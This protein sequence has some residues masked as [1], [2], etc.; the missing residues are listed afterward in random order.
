MNYPSASPFRATLLVLAGVLLVGFA[1]ARAQLILDYEINLGGHV[2][3]PDTTDTNGLGYWSIL[4]PTGTNPNTT[5]SLLNASDG[6]T[7][8]TASITVAG[9]TLSSANGYGGTALNG[10]YPTGNTGSGNFPFIYLAGNSGTTGSITINGLDPSKSYTFDFL[11]SRLITTG[12][13]LGTYSFVGAN[14]GTTGLIDLGST[15]GLGNPTIQVVSGITP[16]AGGVITLNDLSGSSNGGGIAFLQIFE[17]VPEPSTV[18]LAIIGGLGLF[19]V[20]LRRRHQA[21][22]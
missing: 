16:T 4:I 6:T 15:D 18:A 11:A 7:A 8:A 3:N 22:I 10:L 12:Q 19:F 2:T 13:R 5:L 14:S 1:P 9:F 17:S 21:Q 20:V